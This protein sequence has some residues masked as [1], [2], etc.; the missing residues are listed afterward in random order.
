[1]TPTT[2]S[3]AKQMEVRFF[4]SFRSAAVAD[5]TDGRVDGLTYWQTDR[6]AGSSLAVWLAGLTECG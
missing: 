2:G 1:M 6:W 4:E 3:A 5:W